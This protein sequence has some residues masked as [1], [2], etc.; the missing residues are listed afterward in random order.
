[1]LAA[2][3]SLRE[4]LGLVLP[5]AGLPEEAA[6]RRRWSRAALAGRLC[7]LSAA[8]GVGTLTLAMAL[9]RD[10]QAEGETTAW[11]TARASTFYP[12]DAATWGIDL[13]ALPVVRVPDGRAIARAAVQLARSGAFGLIVLDLGARARLAPAAQSR[14]AQCAL[15]DGSAILCLTEKPERSPSLGSLISLRAQAWR[16]RDGQGGFT[17]GIAVAKDKRHGPGWTDEVRCHA[18]PGLR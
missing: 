5:S 4:R 12:P 13:G 7:E 6:P 15:R 8:P 11:V 1:M 16:E 2:L 3:E 17:C 9:V 10:A 14:L 18:P